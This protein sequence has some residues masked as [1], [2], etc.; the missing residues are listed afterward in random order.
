[1]EMYR[2]IPNCYLWI[3]P[4]SGHGVP[5]GTNNLMFI[6]KSLEFLKGEW[7]TNNAPR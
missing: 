2:N 7:E 1:M 6:E 5:E 4:N 3:I